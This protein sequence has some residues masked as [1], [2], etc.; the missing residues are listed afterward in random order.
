MAIDVIIPYGGV[1]VYRQLNLTHIVGTWEMMESISPTLGWAP[2]EPWIKANA[3]ADALE[4]SQA[5]WII[6]TDGDVW[7]ENMATFIDDTMRHENQWGIP[8]RSIDRLDASSTSRVLNG[9]AWGGN[10]A[11]PS[12]RSVPGGGTVMLRR[13]MYNQVPMDPRFVGWGYEDECWGLAL[14]TMFG[15][16]YRGSDPMWHLW[17]P[18]APPKTGRVSSAES[19]ELRQRYH[20]AAYKTKLMSQLLAEV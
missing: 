20:Q 5:E 9:G 19:R 17:H 1:D 7:C 12:Y 15:E 11:K 10:L 16:P 2:A 4:H 8:H 3:V 6:V 14:M 18:P 13:E